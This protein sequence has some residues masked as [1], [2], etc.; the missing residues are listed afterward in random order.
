MVVGLLASCSSG[1]SPDVT[2]DETTSLVELEEP[3]KVTL[4]IYLPAS[5]SETSPNATRATDKYWDYESNGTDNEDRMTTCR[6]LVF[7][8]EGN[9]LMV[10]DPTTSGRFTQ[11]VFDYNGYSLKCYH[12]EQMLS[13]VPGGSF[14]VAVVANMTAD[15]YDLITSDTTLDQL[16]KL[17]FSVDNTERINIKENGVPMYGEQSYSSET[18][19]KRVATDLGEI[20]M[21]RSVAKLI[22]KMLSGVNYK[23]KG[24]SVKNVNKSGYLTSY[25]PDSSVAEIKFDSVS[26][27]NYSCYLPCQPTGIDPE[28]SISLESTVVP[29]VKHTF[30]IKFSDIADAENAGLADDEKWSSSR[31]A[32][33]LNDCVSLGVKSVLG[34]LMDI[35]LNIEDWV[36]G[37][38]NTKEYYSVESWTVSETTVASSKIEWTES[39]SVKVDTSTKTVYIKSGSTATATLTFPVACKWVATLTYEN[40]Y[41]RDIFSFTGNSNGTYTGSGTVALKIN[42]ADYI[43]SEHNVTLQVGMKPKDSSGSYNEGTRVVNVMSGWTIKPML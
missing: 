20:K 15:F 37:T 12:V 30:N 8:S 21:T 27:T 5:L 11:S 19:S 13:C 31:Y 23:I 40:E 43:T 35:N 4:S 41:D 24:A 26:D 6:V 38:E 34:G 25:M 7:D 2:I 18:F 32:L 28:V 1:E 36:D 22:V 33:G 16:K 9:Q 29:G 42:C 39:E 14:K 3:L 10:I 17:W